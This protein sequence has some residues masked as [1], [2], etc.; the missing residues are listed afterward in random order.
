MDLRHRSDYNF[1]DIN[2]LS[3]SGAVDF[4]WD[5]FEPIIGESTG[6]AGPRDL[7]QEAYHQARSQESIDRAPQSVRRE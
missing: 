6:L 3:P 2:H 7:R 1:E 4:A 5:H